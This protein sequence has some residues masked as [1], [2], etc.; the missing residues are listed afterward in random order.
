MNVYSQCA[1]EKVK[2][3]VFWDSSDADYNL[4]Q[5][6]ISKL[7]QT[8]VSAGEMLLGSELNNSPETSP[9]L[10][11]GNFAT[12]P[13]YTDEAFFKFY[14]AMER[15]IFYDIGKI[16]AI[17]EFCGSFLYEKSTGVLPPR[18]VRIRVSDNAERWQ[19]AAVI[20][21]IELGD[22]DEVMKLCAKFEKPLKARFVSISFNVDCWCFCD[23]L[24]VFGTKSLEGAA[25]IIPEREES[26]RFPNRYVTPDDY[27]GVH[28]IMLAY[29]CLHRNPAAGLLSKDKFLPYVAYYNKLG[30]MSDTFFDSFLFLPFVSAAPSGG[31]YYDNKQAPG[32][33][34]DWQYYVDNTF[35]PDYNVFALNE[36]VAEMKKELKLPRDHKVNV[37]LSILFPTFTQRDFGDIDGSGRSLDFNNI[38]D[39]KAAIRWLID[40]QLRRFNDADLD[41]LKLIGYYWF[42]EEVNY[43]NAADFELIKYTT[44][45]VRSLGF[46]TIWI[47][48]YQAPGFQDWKEFGFEVACMQPNYAFTKNPAEVV[49]ANARTTKK[50]GM[51]VEIEI[52]GLSVEAIAKY[53]MYLKVG[54]QMGYMNALHMYYQNGGPG[55]FYNAQRS[56]DLVVRQVYDDTYRFVKYQYPICNIELENNVFS[57]DGGSIADGKLVS[58]KGEDLIVTLFSA[59]KTGSVTLSN[60]GTFKYI[61]KEGFQNNDRF[62][63]DITDGLSEKQVFEIIITE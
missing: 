38:E 42:H 11:D 41:H 46:T 40:E 10:T 63:V 58:K 12:K 25:D 14:R 44:D 20:T 5:N 60:D 4:F 31:F 39:R 49:Y 3:P 55:E 61:V 18:I 50:L 29:N 57:L 15:T 53:R 62:F 34:S 59:P 33:F 28:D 35:A 21:G 43:A 36:A 51:C 37:F 52:G 22:G 17:Y 26:Q 23:Q 24:E 9:K 2:T 30:R 48:W 19:T 6:L 54:A 13:T 7:P 56:N 16:S 45:Y 32:N 8:I 27:F 1:P 47:P